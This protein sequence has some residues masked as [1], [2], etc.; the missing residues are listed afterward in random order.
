MCGK[1]KA[2]RQTRLAVLAALMAVLMAALMAVLLGEPPFGEGGEGG[3]GDVQAGASGLEWP[4]DIRD[5]F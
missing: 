2:A 5:D 4:D 3:L 1:L